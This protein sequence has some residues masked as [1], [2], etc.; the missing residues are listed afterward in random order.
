[1]KKPRRLTAAFCRAVKTA[2]AYGDGRGGYG[3]IL[4]VHQAKGG[5]ITK[6]WCQRIR[7]PSGRVTHVGLG[8]YPLVTLGEARE[9]A[10][11]NA[12]AIRQGRDPRQ[13]SGV[14]T[15]AAAAAEVIAQR[16]K[17]WKPRTGLRE[18]WEQTLR[19]FACPYFGD[20]PVNK[21][22]R[23]DVLA[24]VSPIWSTKHATA[25]LVLQRMRTVLAWAVA[26]GHCE[27]NAASE[28]E[29]GLPRNGHK[30]AHRAAIPYSDLSGALARIRASGP[31]SATSARLCVEFLALTGVR[32]SE[33][34]GARWSE[35]DLDA[36][37]WTVPAGRMKTRRE[38]RVPLSAEALVVLSEARKLHHGAVV[39]PAPTSGGPLAPVALRR[40]FIRA[41]VPGTLHGLRT[42]LRSW[43]ADQGVERE[44]GEAVL[45]H[46][47]GGVEGAYQRSDLL[48]RRR[49]VMED[50]GEFIDP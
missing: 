48:E 27:R 36:R 4:R 7:P 43:C 26:A 17:T 39:F 11:L 35:V 19:D 46:V 8:S 29:G 13:P 23:G 33:A 50:W 40:V 20:K 28:A 18:H 47:V 5:R 32:S 2:G 10:F 31:R 22:T 16:A 12:R 1:M 24:A 45:A 6:A 25:R 21:V 42:A 34:R 3:L 49:E 9:A 30:T 37:L 14:P 15:F 44:V 41:D 38:H